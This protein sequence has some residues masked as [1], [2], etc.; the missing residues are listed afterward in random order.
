MHADVGW[1]LIMWKALGN[2]GDARFCF[3]K[4]LLRFRPTACPGGGSDG[5]SVRER[6]KELPSLYVL[7]FPPSALLM[8]LIHRRSVVS[9]DGGSK[10]VSRHVQEQLSQLQ[11]GQTGVWAAKCVCLLISGHVCFWFAAGFESDRAQKI[12]KINDCVCW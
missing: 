10:R 8:W 4:Q 12:K 3:H 7:R 11:L 5:W 9:C 1:M 6:E 2:E